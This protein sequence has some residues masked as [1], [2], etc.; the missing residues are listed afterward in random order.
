MHAKEPYMLH[1]EWIDQPASVRE[2]ETLDTTKLQAYLHEHLPNAGQTLTVAQFPSGYSNLT[3][4]LR[5]GNQELVLR[6]P[7][8]G[9]NIK[10]AHDM[11]REYR[12]L[13]ALIDVYRKVPRPLLYCDDPAIIGAPFYV[14]ERATGIILRNRPP[15]GLIITPQL[16]RQICMTLVDTLAELHEID[17][18]ACGLAD[19]GQPQGYIERQVNGWTKRYSAAQTD[20]IPAMEATAEWLHNHMPRTTRATLIHNDF[21]YDNVVL[22]PHDPTRIIAVLDWEMATIGDPLMDLGTTLGYW[23]EADDPV[24]LRQFGLTSLPG[25]LSRDEFIQRYAECSG[26]DVSKIL[27]Y[28]VYGLFKVAVI[29]QQIY[30]RYRQGY[31]SDSRFAALIHVVHAC[32][33]MATQA[34]DKNRIDR[35]W[36]S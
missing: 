27:F 14:M 34:L 11:A 20:D 9:A 17:Y 10:S 6:R 5:L 25:N 2:R 33:R 13:S 21:K 30:A 29:V 18:A 24:E 4:L 7:P 1:D 16:M 15:R 31:T 35:L 8:L 36:T 12:L 22:D 3:Y 23:A 26:Q 19:L 28:Y 32:S